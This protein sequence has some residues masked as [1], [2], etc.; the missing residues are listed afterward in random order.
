MG[1]MEKTPANLLKLYRD[2]C[3]LRYFE[4]MAAEKY[5]AGEIPGFVHLYIGEEAVAVGVCAALTNEDVVTSTH[6]GHGHAI[7]KG[8]PSGE[9]LAELF[10]K[11]GGCNG[12]R[13]GSMDM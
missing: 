7:A 2:M 1:S 4:E 9:A 11:Q 8:I 6:R 12:G 5:K 13:G 10:G 3:R